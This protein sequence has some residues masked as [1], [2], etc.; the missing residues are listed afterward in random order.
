[1]NMHCFNKKSV[2]RKYD[3]IYDILKEFYDVR[4]QYYTKR[5]EHQ[6]DELEKELNVLDWKM[7]FIKGVI[8][9][10]II[11]NNRNK[12]NINEQLLKLEFPKLSENKSYDYLVLMPIYSLSKEKIDELQ[13]KID[14]LEEELELIENTTELDKWKSELGELKKHVE[15]VYKASEEPTEEKVPV[16]KGKVK[17]NL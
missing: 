1:M 15:K 3:T 16:G 13:K 10:S 7:K 5:K 8:D 11:V 6:I 14:N 2:I 9:G 12:E 4:L 17:I